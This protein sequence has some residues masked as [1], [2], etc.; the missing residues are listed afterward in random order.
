MENDCD[1]LRHKQKSAVLM[2]DT[3]AHL[4]NAFTKTMNCEVY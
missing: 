1:A 3:K 2:K 4:N